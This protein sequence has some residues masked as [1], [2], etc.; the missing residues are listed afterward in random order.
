MNAHQRRVARRDLTRM[1]DA[2][3]AWDER[4]SYFDD[5]DDEDERQACTACF[6]DGRD[7]MS[8]YLLPCEVC[9]GDGYFD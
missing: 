4:D 8:D 3:D 5:Y 1:A 7:S 9:G 2:F 6:G